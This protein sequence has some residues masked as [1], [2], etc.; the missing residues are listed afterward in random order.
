VWGLR[1]GVAGVPFWLLAAALLLAGGMGA[2]CLIAPV[3]SRLLRP[4]GLDPRSAVH[5]VAAIAFA[6]TL[7]LAAGDFIELQSTSDE[8][9]PIYPTDPF[10]SFLSD[11]TLAL[12]GVGLLQTRTLRAAIARLDLKPLGM[13]QLAWAVA[14]AALLRAS[15]GLM[16]HAESILFP[17]LSALEDRFDY[18]F[19]NIPPLVGA[20]LVSFSAGAGEE[21]LFRGALQPR[22]GIVLTALLFATTHTQYQ[23][24]GLVM[25][26]LVGIA[27]GLMKQRTS[28]T[29]VVSVHALYDIGAFLLPDL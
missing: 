13:R 27:L 28:T 9:T 29:F 15:I 7:L 10:A 11:T 18:E 6:L 20:I 2:G 24:P 1:I 17:A 14:A 22:L 25:I 21:I 16:E 23:L 26:F 5:T 12:A 4:L 3:R 19:V 8:A